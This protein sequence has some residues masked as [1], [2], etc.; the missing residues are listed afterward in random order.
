MKMLSLMSLLMISL[1]LS[2][3]SWTPIYNYPIQDLWDQPRVAV[4]ADDKVVVGMETIRTN[5]PLE[6][7]TDGGQNWTTLDTDFQYKFCGFD[8]AGNL[9][10]VSMKKTSGVSIN[11][12]DSLHFMASGQTTLQAIADLP[13]NGFNKA[14]YYI[15]GDDN[16]YTLSPNLSANLKNQWLLYNNGM[17][18]TE[19][20]TPFNVGS[21]AQRSMLKT[22][23][24]RFVVSTYNSGVRWSDDGQTWNSNQDNHLGNTTWAYIA[25]ANNGDLFM[26][27]TA[28]AQSTDGGN[29]WSSASQSVNLVAHVKKATNGMLFAI[30]PFGGAWQSSDNGATWVEITSLPPYGSDIYDFAVSN[31]YMYIAAKDSTLYRAPLPAVSAVEEATTHSVRIYPNPSSNDVHLTFQDGVGATWQV[32]VVGINGQ[33]VHQAEVTGSTYIITDRILPASGT[34]VVSIRDVE[35]N[36]IQQT[37]IMKLR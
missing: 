2:S 30:S 16:L 1:A 37:K 9:Y 10:A 35:G 14:F 36:L 21:S 31:N 13:N 24:G 23:S 25:E 27:G 11:Y 20:E 3:Q 6:L 17:P 7:T 33:L 26:G 22:A 8:G 5:R 15:D 12:T 19:I 18:G 28:L 32:V 29:T 4:S 34:Y